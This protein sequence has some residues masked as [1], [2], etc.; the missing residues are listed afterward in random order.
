M[1]KQ[2]SERTLKAH[3]KEKASIDYYMNK[4]RPIP[5]DYEDFVENV[6]FDEDNFIFYN[7][8]KNTAY[9]TRCGSHFEIKKDFKT[10]LK[11]NRSAVCPCCDKVTQCKS[12]GMSRKGLLIPQWSVMLEK[13]EDLV[14]TRYFLHTKDFTSN[15][16]N[17]EIKTK[18]MFRTVHTEEGSFD[19]EYSTFKSTN[20]YRWCY[21]KGRT[22]GYYFPSEFSMP[23]STYIYNENISSVI[24]GTCMKYSCLDLYVEKFIHG[25]FT[26]KPWQL[27]NFMNSYREM[28]Y[29]EKLLKV[30]FYSLVQEILSKYY[31]PKLKDGKTVLETLEIS[32][33]N[34][35][36]LRDVGDPFWEDVK[37]LRYGQSLNKKE[38]EILRNVGSTYEK[39]IDAKPY[40]TIYKLHKYISQN[41]ID[42]NDY[43]DYLEWI[44][45]MGYEMRNSFN[46]FPKD[47]KRAHDEK[48]KEFLKFQSNKAKEEC[49]RFNKLLKDMRTNAK[50]K[51]AMELK[52][53]GLFIRLPYSTQE[54]KKEGE[55]LHHCVGTYVE[56]V[57]KGK[58]MI[59]FIRKEE[60]P[61]KPYFTLEY[62]DNH[63]V[64]CRGLHNCD[65]N[66]NVRA[67]K[68]IFEEKMQ[69]E[70]IERW[71]DL[72]TK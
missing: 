7:T 70:S 20:V 8:K 48:S 13:C 46:L 71:N 1:S 26:Q 28:P 44:R 57:I 37:I 49:K 35:K 15:V 41:N 64:Q 3:E 29:V 17:P 33:N 53:D 63:V 21:M 22:Y 43:F 62:K 25:R 66:E 23:R 2:L 68:E 9:C 16:F 55:T 34:F 32:K 24:S 11:H 30:G 58:T 27:D 36:L 18:E 6:V 39:Y 5:S 14:F 54:I 12:D 19:Y 45:K 65:M 38:F 56:R 59:F 50:G 61:D 47:F 42:A 69:S 67:F 40:T 60:A 51:G 10:S 31:V 72:L 52:A 4:F